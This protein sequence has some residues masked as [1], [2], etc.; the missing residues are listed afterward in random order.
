VIFFSLGRGS[1]LRCLFDRKRESQRN[2]NGP[3]DFL[4]LHDDWRTFGTGVEKVLGHS[5][6]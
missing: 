4:L 5:F 2:M 1:R 6:R 3:R